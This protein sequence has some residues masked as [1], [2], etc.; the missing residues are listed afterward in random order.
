MVLVTVAVA[1]FPSLV[2]EFP[3]AVGAAKK[4]KI[5]WKHG[6][7][8]GGSSLT[9]SFSK[10]FIL[11]KIA[12]DRLF[13]LFTLTHVRVSNREALLLLLTAISVHTS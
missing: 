8:Y 9:R 2:W 11:P 13:L 6:S 4:K 3:H 5:K 1:Q 10:N 12:L 7:I